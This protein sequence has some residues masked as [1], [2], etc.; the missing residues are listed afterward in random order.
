MPGVS[1]RMRRLLL[2][3]GVGR[4]DRENDS[5]VIGAARLG[6][7]GQGMAWHGMG[8]YGRREEEQKKCVTTG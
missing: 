5:E 1:G 6:K 2:R 7:A 8:P 4:C 3:G